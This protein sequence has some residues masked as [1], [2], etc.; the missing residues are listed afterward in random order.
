MSGSTNGRTYPVGAPRL[1]LFGV[2]VQA[3]D[4]ASFRQAPPPGQGVWRSSRS[5]VPG[6]L[7]KRLHQDKAFGRFGVSH[8]RFPQAPYGT[9]WGPIWTPFG[10][11]DDKTQSLVPYPKSVSALH[12]RSGRPAFLLSAAGHNKT[13]PQSTQMTQST[14][15]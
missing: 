14:S 4:A 12:S 8:R 11:S 15:Q 10:F 1:S 13:N 7:A 3:L 6:V 5:A 2:S 9:Q